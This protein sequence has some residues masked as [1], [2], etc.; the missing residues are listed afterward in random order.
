MTTIYQWRI[1]CTTDNKFEYVWNPD[2]PT[3]CPSNIN[4]AIDSTKTTVVDRIDPNFIRIQE[5]STPTGNNFKIETKVLTSP[6]VGISKLDIRWPFPVSIFSASFVGTTDH[7]G[8]VFNVDVSPNTTIGVLTANVSTGDTIL[9]VTPTVI[10]YLN[11]GRK[12]KISDGTNVNNLGYVI[13]INEANNQITVDTAVVNNFSATSPTYVIM[14]VKLIEDFE[15]GPPWEYEFAKRKIGGTYV[16]ANTLIQLSYDNKTNTPKK[17]IF[18]I[19]F[20]Y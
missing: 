13:N 15:I 9:N 8:D 1:R 6:G 12:V 10:E 17:L 7:V 5:E 18:A 4:H 11:I 3:K 16:P 2:K 20:T 14:T 19:E